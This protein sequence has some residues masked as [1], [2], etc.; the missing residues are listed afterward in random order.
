MPNTQT[1]LIAF[2]LTSSISLILP[3]SI[4]PLID[5]F[6]SRYEALSK[7]AP[8]IYNKL[9]CFNIYWFQSYT[10]DTTLYMNYIYCCYSCFIHFDQFQDIAV[11][12]ITIIAAFKAIVIYV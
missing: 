12:D 3:D 8:N 4:Y 6:I 7:F 10:Y 2:P 11:T 9:I 1:V 5:D